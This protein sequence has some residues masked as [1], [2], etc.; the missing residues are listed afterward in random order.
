MEDNTN[1]YPNIKLNLPKVR[2][3]FVGNTWT[4]VARFI[5]SPTGLANQ[6]IPKRA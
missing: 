6:S 3:V 1:K 4:L 5:S 2:P